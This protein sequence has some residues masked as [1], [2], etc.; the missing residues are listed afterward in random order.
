MSE[1]IFHT[2][3]FHSITPCKYPESVSF[4]KTPCIFQNI[5]D[6]D[7]KLKAHQGEKL[8]LRTH[9]EKFIQQFSV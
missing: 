3:F 9:F 2:L 8:S 6:W 4:G 5:Q 7:I 1:T